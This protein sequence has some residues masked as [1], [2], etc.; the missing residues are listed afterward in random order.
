MRKFRG[1]FVLTII[2]YCLFILNFVSSSCD[3]GQVNINTASLEELDKLSGVGPAYAQNI[4]DT[5]PFDSVDNLIDVKGIGP[6]TL[7]KIKSQGLACVGEESSVN[8]DKTSESDNQTNSREEPVLDNNLIVKEDISSIKN[9]EPEVITLN[10]EASKGIKTIESNSISDRR[11]Y[12][13][14]G[15][16]AFSI[17]LSALFWMRSRK[18]KNEFR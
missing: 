2:F 8:E 7:E 6:T 12:A 17:L 4:I 18:Y 1:L 16:V 13:T 15:L 14:Y 9:Q 5:R 11:T 10:S 3:S